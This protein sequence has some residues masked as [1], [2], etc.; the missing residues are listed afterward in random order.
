[1]REAY[2]LILLAV[3]A[4][5]LSRTIL[6]PVKKLMETVATFERGEPLPDAP[7]RRQDELG[8]LA[9]SLRSA[10]VG[11]TES[12]GRLQQMNSQLESRVTERT[13][14]LRRYTRELR[15]ARTETDGNQQHP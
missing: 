7:S 1:M 2:L 14:Q 6:G 9:T 15:H 12:H 11:V 8:T 4:F 10:L 13:G 3:L 5:S